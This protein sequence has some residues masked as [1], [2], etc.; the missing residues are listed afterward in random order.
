MTRSTEQVKHDKLGGMRTETC[1]L[2]DNKETKLI[3]SVTRYDPQTLHLLYFSCNI[4][5]KDSS[6]AQLFSIAH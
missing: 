2:N 3:I 5:S 6:H 1:L 4:V